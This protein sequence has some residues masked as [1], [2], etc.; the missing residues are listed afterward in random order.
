MQCAHEHSVA[1]GAAALHPRAERRGRARRE[2]ALQS[3]CPARHAA[4]CAKRTRGRG[5]QRSVHA[6][7]WR[8][9]KV[10]DAAFFCKDGREWVLI[11]DN[12]H[13]PCQAGGAQ[14]GLPARCVV[15]RE[16]GKRSGACPQ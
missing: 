16:T 15:L 8:T 12:M 1:L 9:G 10:P 4:R 13:A 3:C 5:K 11:L 6:L 14:H 7:R 2:A